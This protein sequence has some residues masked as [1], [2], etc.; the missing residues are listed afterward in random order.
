MT[1]DVCIGCGNDLGPDDFFEDDE[2]RP[3]VVLDGDTDPEVTEGPY[4]IR[5][6]RIEVGLGIWRECPTCGGK[7]K[8]RESGT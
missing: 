4:C 5:C 1:D 3:Y 7:G 8:V 6:F 2:T